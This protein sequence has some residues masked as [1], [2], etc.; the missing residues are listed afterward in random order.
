MKGPYQGM[1][2]QIINPLETVCQTVHEAIIIVNRDLV[3]QLVNQAAYRYCGLTE[4]FR[5]QPFHSIT[6]TCGAKLA[7]ALKQVIAEKRPM[8]QLQVMCQGWDRHN[9]LLEATINPVL[10]DQGTCQG[11]VLAI[12]DRTRM[13]GGD[14][15]PNRRNRF[16]RLLGSSPGME[17]IYSLIENLA[18]MNTTVLITGESGVGKELAAEAIHLQSQRASKPLVKV[19]CSALSD[20]LLES[21]LFGHVKGA[22]TGAV[23]DRLGR[24][25]LADQG[26]IFLDEI[27]DISPNMQVRLLRV[28]QEGEFERVGDSHTSRVDVRIV[29]ATNQDLRKKVAKETFRE[30]LYYRLNVVE[31]PMPPLR[32]RK[33]D[34][35]LLVEHFIIKFNQKHGKAISAVNSKVMDLFNG[36][37]WPGNVRELEH[38]IEHAFVTCREPVIKLG[39]LP[40]SL[41][42][43]DVNIREIP[44]AVVEIEQSSDEKEAILRA[45]EA[46]HWKK[47]RAAELLGM[48][49]SS[50][51]RKIEQYGITA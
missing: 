41:F 44:P 22:F 23:K 7:D 6:T 12:R 31:I 5:G 15:T 4:A 51:Y 42:N 19:N 16:H 43:P 26:T 37:P 8:Q 18:P 34:I 50:L 39:H 35:P 48:S 29:A 33:D 40:K 30:D 46:T 45:L 27:G 1:E 32:E 36:Y 3:I 28:L 10:D 49:R 9:I 17:E 25:Q 47:N 2:N 38:V 13:I 14:V 24:F 20:T 11:A 21:E